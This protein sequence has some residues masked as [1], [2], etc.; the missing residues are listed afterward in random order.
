MDKSI[1]L[2]MVDIVLETAALVI[3]IHLGNL[4]DKVRDGGPRDNNGMKT[5][6]WWTIAFGS[7]L[8]CIPY[9]IYLLIQMT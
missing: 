9:S 2:S 5:E 3:I 6:W 7:K 8:F 1:V 4:I